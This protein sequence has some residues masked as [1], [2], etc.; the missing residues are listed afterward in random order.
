MHATLIRCH[1]LVAIAVIHSIVAGGMACGQEPSQARAAEA[2]HGAYRARPPIMPLAP[3]PVVFEGFDLV[4][5]QG[6]GSVAAALDECASDSHPA[7]EMLEFKGIDVRGPNGRDAA[8]APMAAEVR[9]R[10]D[11][12][13][14]AA[15]VAANPESIGHGPSQWTGRI[16]MSNDRLSG[17]ESFE[18]RT[19]LAPSEMA[20]IVGVAA[21]PRFERRFRRGLTVFIDGQAEARAFRS[22]DA[23]WLPVPGAADGS[24]AT[25]GVTARTGFVR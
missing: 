11:R 14:V 5:F 1:A 10:I 16:G 25:V 9:S 18:L 17:S 20:S 6:T 2:A 21:G 3:P 8:P 15:G 13:D 7:K 19:M 22:A 4:D 12:I 24:L 23:S